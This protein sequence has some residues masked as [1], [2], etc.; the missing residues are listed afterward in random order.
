MERT[1]EDTLDIKAKQEEKHSRSSRFNDLRLKI[2]SKKS[3]KSDS[4]SESSSDIDEQ[5]LF[6]K[7]VERSIDVSS[8]SIES[9]ESR[10]V[11]DTN[12]LGFYGHS[13]KK[14]SIPKYKFKQKL[15]SFNFMGGGK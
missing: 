4:G 3:Q 1:D 14:K 15:N 12:K 9:A 11:V 8:R 13:V 2:S 5:H 7:K 6:P 10:V